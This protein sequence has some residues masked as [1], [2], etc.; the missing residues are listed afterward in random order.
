MD[1]LTL[2]TSLTKNT[3]MIRISTSSTGAILLKKNTVLIKWGYT[4]FKLKVLS[5]SS[6]I[7]KFHINKGTVSQCQWVMLGIKTIHRDLGGKKNGGWASTKLH[8]LPTAP[9]VWISYMCT[10]YHTV[11]KIIKFMRL[12]SLLFYQGL[13]LTE[14]PC[15]HE[16]FPFITSFHLFHVHKCFCYIDCKKNK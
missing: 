3:S 14:L 5:H 12:Y 1:R 4:P 10:A 7:K 9:N 16:A 8:S 13:T 11:H 15:K 2:H 6:K